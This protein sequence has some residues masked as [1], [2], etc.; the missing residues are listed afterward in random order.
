MHGA[1]KDLRHHGLD[2]HSSKAY[3]VI[4]EEAWSR[5]QAQQ[6]V[7]TTVVSVAETILAVID[8]LIATV[9]SVK[10]YKPQ[11][12]AIIAPILNVNTFFLRIKIILK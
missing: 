7:S 8:M 9:P 12:K 4:I 1:G 2:D 5:Y 11:F 3:K 6:G 10:R